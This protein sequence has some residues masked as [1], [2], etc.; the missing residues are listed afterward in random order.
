M[1][2]FIASIMALLFIGSLA[3]IGLGCGSEKDA[4]KGEEEKA[5]LATERAKKMDD[6][7]GDE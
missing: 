1:K 7:F 5:G 2:K 4:D 3:V 6:P